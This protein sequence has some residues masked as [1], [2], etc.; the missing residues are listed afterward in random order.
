MF[1]MYLSLFSLKCILTNNKVEIQPAEAGI[2]FNILH[3]WNQSIGK[4]A[5][6]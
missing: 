5:E 1:S 3:N 4:T 2:D 6:A